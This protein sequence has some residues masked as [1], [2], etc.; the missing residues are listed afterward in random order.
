MNVETIIIDG[1]KYMEIDKIEVKDNT[2]VYLCNIDDN[3]DFFIR[4]LVKSDDKL[5]YL[6]LKDNDEF[7][8]ALM[9]FAKKHENLIQE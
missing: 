5:C 7:D 9:Y 4:K 8:L 2:Y 3:S 6:G 1:K